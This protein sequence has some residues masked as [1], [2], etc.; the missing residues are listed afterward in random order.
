MQLE[1]GTRPSMESYA[2]I[3]TGL[4]MGAPTAEVKE[5]E[6]DECRQGAVVC[7]RRLQPAK[8][9]MSGRLNDARSFA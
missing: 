6:A 5:E 4:P 3:D 9:V 1:G 8:A 2:S 7:R